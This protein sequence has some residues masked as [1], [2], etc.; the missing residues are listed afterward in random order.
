MPGGPLIVSDVMKNSCTLTW[1]PPVSD[2]GAT[3]TGYII[4]MRDVLGLS[5]WSRVDRVSAHTYTYTVTHLLEG[6]KY[7]FKVIAENAHGRSP[8]LETRTSVE[9]RSPYSESYSSLCF[10]IDLCLI[11][12]FIEMSKTFWYLLISQH[13]PKHLL[14]FASSV[15]PMSH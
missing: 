2:G 10:K 5:V 6:D 9:T 13:L 3:I 8:A 15:F 1:Q 11:Y 14:T 7:L 12:V 4:E